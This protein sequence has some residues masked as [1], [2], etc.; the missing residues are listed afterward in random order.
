MVRLPGARPRLMVMGCPS[1][2]TSLPTLA[3]ARV[4]DPTDTALAHAQPG[5]AGD[6]AAELWFARR[7]AASAATGASSVQDLTGLQVRWGVN[8]DRARV[9]TVHRTT[10]VRLKTNNASDPRRCT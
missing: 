5:Q 1:T 4:N 10:L 9:W 2:P 7:A 3:A 6:A 8:R